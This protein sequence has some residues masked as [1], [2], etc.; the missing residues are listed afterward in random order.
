MIFIRPASLILALF[1]RQLSHTQDS[2]KS[3]ICGD[4][5]DPLF[6]AVSTTNHHPKCNVFISERCS[7][8]IGMNLRTL[9]LIVLTRTLPSRR[10]AFAS[11]LSTCRLGR[12]DSW[13]RTLSTT[14]IANSCNHRRED[15]FA[16]GTGE[17]SEVSIYLQCKDG[18]SIP[19]VLKEG[20]FLAKGQ[21]RSEGFA[22]NL[23]FNHS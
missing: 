5:R 19:N 16:S 13:P 23:P 1:T 20:R 10:C 22:P 7:K 17:V 6:R 14:K 11:Y 4:E 9:S 2:E 12:S 8:M 18:D 15:L 21:G 3:G